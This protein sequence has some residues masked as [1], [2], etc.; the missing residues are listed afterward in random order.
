M[1]K[2]PKRLPKSWLDRISKNPISPDKIKIETNGGLDPN[3]GYETGGGTAQEYRNRITGSVFTISES[4]VADSISAYI[5]AEEMNVKCAI[6]KESDN[7]L[8]GET[9]EKIELLILPNPVWETFNFSTPKPE[10]SA[11]TAYVLVI[12]GGGPPESENAIYWDEGIPDQ[13]RYKEITYNNF[14]SSIT[15][16]S[17]QFARK[18]SI[19]CS[20][21]AK[22]LKT[23]TDSADSAEVVST[24]WKFIADSVS[25]KEVITA[26]GWNTPTSIYSKCGEEAGYE[27]IKSIDENIS[28]Y[29]SH[30]ATEFHQIIYDMDSS[31]YVK[32]V[33][34]Y[35]TSPINAFGRD[36]GIKV[37]VSDDPANWGIS[38]W[39]GILETANSWNLSGQFSKKGRYIKIE[40]K[41]DD[42][43]QWLYE[44]DA[45]IEYPEFKD[46]SDSLLS[47]ETMLRAWSKTLLDSAWLFEADF[48]WKQPKEVHSASYDYQRDNIIDG[49]LSTFWFDYP[50]VGHQELW[51]VLD[52]GMIGILEN[53][54][55]YMHSD[56]A[57][58]RSYGMQIYVSTTPSGWGEAVWS[59]TMTSTGWN[60]TGSF[61]KKGRYIKIF[62]YI[63]DVTYEENA[64]Y[65]CQPLVR[66][67]DKALLFSEVSNCK[68][69][70]APFIETLDATDIN[71]QAT[72]PCKFH[73]LGSEPVVKRRFQ[74]YVNDKLGWNLGMYQRSYTDPATTGDWINRTP[75]RTIAAS[76]SSAEAKAQA[77]Y[78]CDGIYDEEQFHLAFASL[79]NG[80]KVFL[81]NGT[82][83]PTLANISLTSN[84]TLQGESRDGV[85]IHGGPDYASGC[86]L[87]LTGG[88]N[89]LVQDLTIEGDQG[90]AAGRGEGIWICNNAE[91]EVIRNCRV[92]DVAAVGIP[93]EAAWGTVRNIW[94][95]NCEVRD[96]G[97]YGIE[98]YSAGPTLEDIYCFDNHV[99]DVTSS[100]YE[101]IYALAGIP[102]IGIN[103]SDVSSGEISNNLVEGSGRAGILVQRD[104]SNVLIQGNEVKNNGAQVP[105]SEGL[106]VRGKEGD[107]ATSITL[108]GNKSYDNATGTQ[109]Y[110]IFLN[111]YTS[112]CLGEENHLSGNEVAIIDENE[113]TIR[114]NIGVRLFTS[115]ILVEGTGEFSS[116]VS[117]LWSG[118]QY[119]FRVETLFDSFFNIDS[120]KEFETG[121][122]I[123][124]IL[125]GQELISLFRPLAVMDE[126][127]TAEV[128]G[129]LNRL[130]ILDSS[131]PSE[132]VSLLV[133][134]PITDS[135]QIG[136]I[137]SLLNQLAV[138]DSTQIL[139][140]IALL[141]KLT[142]T[143]SISTN[144]ILSFLVYISQLESAQ[145]GEVIDKINMV[146]FS[147]NSLAGDL[148]SLL[149][150]LPTIT[151]TANALDFV[152]WFRRLILTDSTQINEI[153]ENFVGITT[154]DS[155]LSQ[156]ALILIASLIQSD[157]SRSSELLDILSNL[158]IE[159]SAE[160]FE[161]L[162]V[163]IQ[164]LF[165]I[166]QDQA[167]TFESI[168]VPIKRILMTD[169]I[170]GLELLQLTNYLDILDSLQTLEI[171]ELVNQ[172]SITDYTEVSTYLKRAFAITEK[173][174]FEEA[175][176]SEIIALLR[177]V[178]LVES[179]NATEVLDFLGEIRITDAGITQ[180]SI[181]QQLGL[182]RLLTIDIALKQG[183]QITSILEKALTVETALKQA[184]DIAPILK[185]HYELSNIFK[186]PLRIY[187][188]LK[189]GSK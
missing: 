40:S 134:L 165:K 83:Y 62:T 55:L 157:S 123:E 45:F 51:I 167:D 27:A 4:G 80:G 109:K 141:A 181:F 121:F 48:L 63:P 147:D 31:N 84:I 159:E 173:T 65:E 54:R 153:L 115:W 137:V 148:I 133:R 108:R 44:F 140:V 9:E 144:E 17:N 110:G 56:N 19:Y 127:R 90:G 116:I 2:F 39:E 91:N 5:I 99:I 94:V 163:L 186:L 182:L 10:L 82:Y 125:N 156:E 16:S 58:G 142:Q 168:I 25:A 73:F 113:N 188:L 106:G 7:S 79:S 15:F 122:C 135:S 46:I 12:W 47:S 81:F 130:N 78:V 35:V 105:D 85:I 189:G 143:D 185:A 145:V 98:C 124:D 28:T 172:L 136:E 26:P 180:V 158:Q 68:D 30:N 8:V 162:E 3:F 138:Q 95:I 150:T 86:I 174:I 154:T 21:T 97:Q 129:L 88:S 37:F 11:S 92:K 160:S 6:Y 151:E 14:P 139:E 67:E 103:F 34:L 33:K 49:N 132:I 77:D 111:S 177:K 166:V 104:A 112:S 43:A 23:V 71:K 57:F 126:S 131:T 164:Y 155:L 89:R 161:D 100:Y 146:F 184:L 69:A 66:M 101:D 179:L 50:A 74:Y 169:S 60:E 175:E 70:V 52:M 61:H 59:G 36:V 20:Y 53:L 76:N 176:V 187:I 72:L 96:T 13:S 149:V 171:I 87:G 178:F 170:R 41:S 117:D 183:T 119:K 42:S 120:W 64:I 1:F 29:W 18:Y 152:E 102:L 107:I 22:I 32:R 38:V 118:S 93:I 128:L 75:V 24:N 114:N